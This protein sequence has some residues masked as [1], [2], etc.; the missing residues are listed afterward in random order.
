MPVYNILAVGTNSHWEAKNI[1][2]IGE[3]KK[4]Y[5]VSPLHAVQTD[6][7]LKYKKKKEVSPRS[8]IGYAAN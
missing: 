6:L 3:A 1:I 8:P 2:S 7:H 5:I 4:P